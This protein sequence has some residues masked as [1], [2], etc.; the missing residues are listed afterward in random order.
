MCNRVLFHIDIDDKNGSIFYFYKANSC[1][2][3][4]ILYIYWLM[5]LEH[6]DRIRY[7]TIF[8]SLCI[9]HSVLFISFGMI[10]Y[11]CQFAFFSSEKTLAHCGQVYSVAFEC[12]KWILWLFWSMSFMRFSVKIN[13]KRKKKRYGE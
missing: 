6:R 7:Y 2:I 4:C 11:S 12:E 13:S 1:Y 8:V 3:Y 9:L 10:Y 5:Y